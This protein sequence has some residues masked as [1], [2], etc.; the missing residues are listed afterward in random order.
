MGQLKN[1]LWQP[2]W[3]AASGLLPSPAQSPSRPTR[4]GTMWQWQQVPLL[5]RGSVY[6]A[7]ISLPPFLS[8]TPLSLLSFAE[9]INDS[10]AMEMMDIDLE[11]DSES[12]Q[13]L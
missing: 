2:G 4:L 8:H 3:D 6:N 11:T 13:G 1:Q 7:A 10:S 9:L 5:G 12:W